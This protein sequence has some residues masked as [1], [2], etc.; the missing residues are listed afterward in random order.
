L[1]DVLVGKKAY[2]EAI[3][4]Y[5]ALIKK[6]SALSKKEM[7]V[8]YRK[9]S[10]VY[11]YQ[12]NLEKRIEFLETALQQTP[13][14][15][16]LV[17][18]LVDEYFKIGRYYD[19]YSKLEDCRKL[20]RCGESEA[21]FERLSYAYIQIKDFAKA[22]ETLDVAQKAYPEN[23]ELKYLDAL[24]AESLYQLNNAKRLYSALIDKYPQFIK[25]YL[26]ISGIYINE[27]NFDK[28]IGILKTAITKIPE[29]G[30]AHGLLGSIYLRQKDFKNA[31][32][33]YVLANQGFPEDLDYIKNLG[34]VQL[35]LN[36]LDDAI[37]QFEM[38]EKNGVDNPDYL[39]YYA[40]ALMAKTRFPEAVRIYQRV[41]D[42]TS[43]GDKDYTSKVANAYLQLGK[44]YLKEGNLDTADASL[45]NA[46]NLDKTLAL[47]YYY[48]AQI[49]IKRNRDDNAIKLFLQALE[50]D[51]RNLEIRFYLAKTY[52][53][54]LNREYEQ[55]ALNEYNNIV[56][57]YN[58]IKND[59]L[60]NPEVY[61]NRGKILEKRGI[62]D[63]ASADFLQVLD[64]TPGRVDALEELVA[65]LFYLGRYKEMEAVAGTLFEKDT[66]NAMGHYFL[67]KYLTLQKAYDQA[68]LHLE[69]AVPVEDIYPE[70][71][72]LLGFYY[73]EKGMKQKALE[74]FEKFIFKSGDKLDPGLKDDIN[75]QIEILKQG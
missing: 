17:I 30:R 15:Q 54:T 12:R 71:H 68:F 25:P 7:A 28:A 75:R 69:Q 1:G 41:L 66:K 36:D 18:E 4:Y 48:R 22:K 33:A 32:D 58:S 40:E 57:E 8:I 73:K 47:A 72:R 51:P 65:C 38:L 67:G 3:A 19:S 24:L 61:L 16:A 70:V 59:K 6:E 34:I 37:R 56:N 44:I 62:Y 35:R 29:N 55:K 60:K 5:D 13:E 9:I 49:E 23:I 39:E 31:K 63:S 74:S 14:D 10:M 46:L 53:N 20:P 27:S 42:T 2:N 43:K 21:L 50:K 26:G 64:M 52:E 45:L 11:G